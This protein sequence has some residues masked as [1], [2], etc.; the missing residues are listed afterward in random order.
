MAETSSAHPVPFCIKAVNIQQF[1]G[2]V[3]PEVR[4]GGIGTPYFVAAA[5]RFTHENCFLIDFISNPGRQKVTQTPWPGFTT[6]PGRRRL[7]P[8]AHGPRPAENPANQGN[9]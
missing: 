2:V 5:R 4:A 9:Y 8:D 7:P 1:A 3:K 6:G